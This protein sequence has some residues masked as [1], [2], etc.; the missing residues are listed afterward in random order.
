[1]KKL[2]ITLLILLVLISVSGCAKNTGKRV[3][4]SGKPIT[5]SL[6]I[7]EKDTTTKSYV[8]NAVANFSFSN[9]SA[10][11]TLAKDVDYVQVMD[12]RITTSS[13]ILVTPESPHDEGFYQYWVEPENGS[14]T[15]NIE[16][17]SADLWTFNFF[18]SRY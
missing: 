16:P 9:R 4:K 2:I 5:D 3:G 8:Y 10:R 12:S 15:V 6:D 18:I 1:M 13:I 17:A 11:V 14:F 7:I